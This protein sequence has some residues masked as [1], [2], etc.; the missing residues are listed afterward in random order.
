[1][2]VALWTLW[3]LSAVKS[4]YVT[5]TSRT[6]NYFRN[7]WDKQPYMLPRKFRTDRPTVNKRIKYSVWRYHVNT[8][9]KVPDKEER[10]WTSEY[11]NELIP[12][13]R[14]VPGKLFEVFTAGRQWRL[15]TYQ[16]CG[17]V[18]YCFALWWSIRV[19]WLNYFAKT[20]Y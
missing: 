2:L 1:M 3:K 8:K 17:W 10:D 6:E 7:V 15:Y 20:I 13:F 9:S 14:Y 12:S 11:R 18:E 19:S 4:I 16:K 5:M